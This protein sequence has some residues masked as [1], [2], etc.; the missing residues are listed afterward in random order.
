MKFQE[1][2][3]DNDI[4]RRTSG[5]HEP[6]TTID[7]GR[8]CSLLGM[9]YGRGRIR[10]KIQNETLIHLS[11]PD[12]KLD[13][14]AKRVAHL[15]SISLAEMLQN[16]RMTSK[17]KILLA[18]VLARSVWQ[19]YNSDWM[20]AQWSP[21]CI[22]FMWEQTSNTNQR[23]VD[24]GYPY[25]ACTIDESA[26]DSSI[27][28]CSKHSVYHRYP[29]ILALGVL[30]IRIC[31]NQPLNT[32]RHDEALET[33]VNTDFFYGQDL[34]ENESWPDLDLNVQAKK[35]YKSVVKACLNHE[36][37]KQTGESD[38]PNR[39]EI[40]W[41]VAVYPLARLAAAMGWLWLDDGQIHRVDAGNIPGQQKSETLNK[42]N[43]PATL[44]YI[45]T[46][47]KTAPSGASTSS[48]E[49][50]G[51]VNF[52][53]SFSSLSRLLTISSAESRKW[54][55]DI[56]FSDFNVEMVA[57][58]RNTPRIKVAVLDTGYD[59]SSIFFTDP[60]RKSRI[61]RW[62]D[63]VEETSK[64]RQDVDGHGTHVLSLVM[65]VAPI[66]DLYVARIAKGRAAGDLSSASDRIAKVRS[67]L[68]P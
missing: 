10:L 38:I 11:E 35:T 7:R 54:L 36:T 2:S 6:S 24:P 4:E 27:E 62:K 57:R 41:K 25:L 53:T 44:L 26:G 34:L 37:F 39:R 20:K 31:Q 28:Y 56:Q 8:F 12:R 14:H 51:Y 45:H 42:G 65:T 58:F 13:E 47:A 50:A 66:A 33:Q 40:L 15:P 23:A 30:L 5:D 29:L 52:Q 21:D 68:S 64:E 17:N 46:V 59:P 32:P 19:F 61:R 43:S 9:D 18:Y 67:L 22:H 55:N 1:R 60:D 3:V 63:F 49:V 16:Y 48:G